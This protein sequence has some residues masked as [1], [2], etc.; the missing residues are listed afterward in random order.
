MYFIDFKS[1]NIDYFPFGKMKP[2]TDYTELLP[3]IPV[4][5]CLSM[6]YM[7]ISKL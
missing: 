4:I 6:L 3:L 7:T 5:G 1:W 2:V